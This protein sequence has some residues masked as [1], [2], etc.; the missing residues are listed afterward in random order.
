MTTSGPPTTTESPGRHLGDLARGEHRWSVHLETRAEARGGARPVA[1][2]RLHFVGG[3]RRRST[4][5]IFLERSDQEI[6]ARFNEFS[7]NELW[8]LL[9]SLA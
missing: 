8:S 9:D 7:P 5:W 1:H 3:S 2:G 4:A 6:L